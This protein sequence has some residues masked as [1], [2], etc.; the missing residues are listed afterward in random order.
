MIPHYHLWRNS[1][2]LFGPFGGYPQL[3]W[4]IDAAKQYASGLD[5]RACRKIECLIWEMAI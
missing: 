5:V 2:V 4:D 1:M 3:F